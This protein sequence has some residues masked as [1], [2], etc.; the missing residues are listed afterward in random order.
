MGRLWAVCDQVRQGM[1]GRTAPVLAVGVCEQAA[2]LTWQSGSGAA[3]GWD[4]S[5]A[6]LAARVSFRGKVVAV[7]ADQ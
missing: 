1:R 7:V 5:C 6:G 2:V 4:C 3:F